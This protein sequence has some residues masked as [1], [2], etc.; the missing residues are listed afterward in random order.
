MEV[1]QPTTEIPQTLDEFYSERHPTSP[2]THAFLS[3]KNMLHILQM[4]NHAVQQDTGLSNTPPITF[5]EQVLSQLMLYAKEYVA[6]PVEYLENVNTIFVRSMRD[7]MVWEANQNNQYKRW[8]TEGIP[9]PNNV[10][11]P[12]NPDRGAQEVETSDYLLSHPWGG[13]IPRY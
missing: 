12:T 9:D 13:R 5:T 6:T 10:P 2:L 8:E 3:G 11:R 7:G 1:P 4:L